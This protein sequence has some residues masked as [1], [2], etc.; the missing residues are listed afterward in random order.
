MGDAQRTSLAGLEQSL[1]DTLRKDSSDQQKKQKVLDLQRQAWGEEI[2][3]QTDAGTVKPEAREDDMKAT[4][5]SLKTKEAEIEKRKAEVQERVKLQLTRV[6]QEAKRLDELKKD[7]EALEDPTRREVADLRKKIEAIDREIRPLKS[8]CDRK[9]KELKDA[10]AN[11]NEKSEKKNE[12]VGK[13]FELVTESEK[14]RMEK[15]EDLN[16]HLQAMEGAAAA[17][18]SNGYKNPFD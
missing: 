13:L 11:Y 12:L 17:G 6:E 14:M 18:S 3:Q 9:E 5:Q 15:L 8:L 7:L 1:R 10:V 2:K 4:V 16:R